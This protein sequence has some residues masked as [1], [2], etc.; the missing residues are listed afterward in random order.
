LS[1]QSEAIVGWTGMALFAAG[2]LAVLV[3]ATHTD[4]PNP[5]LVGPAIGIA[6]VLALLG[7]TLLAAA[8]VRR[9]H[10]PLGS[11]PPAL[12]RRESIPV[13]PRSPDLA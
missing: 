7:V 5:W 6:A 4:Q 9:R 12:A 2:D 1:E 13:G 8:V 10:A 11:A 3:H